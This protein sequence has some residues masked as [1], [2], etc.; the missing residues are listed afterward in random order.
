MKKAVSFIVLLAMLFTCSF[1]YAGSIA[2]WT[3]YTTADGSY[4]FHYPNS[5]KGWK[6]EANE[7]AVLIE[8]TQTDEQLLMAMIPYNKSKSPTSLAT[9]FINLLKAESPNVR[10][11]NWQTDPQAKNSQVFFDLTDKNNNKQYCGS[12]IV[13][14]DNQQATWFSYISPATG[15]SR[16]RGISLLQGFIG[17][18][19][20]GSG[21]IAPEINY[22]STYIARIDAN[23][24]GFLFV[25]EFA[26]GAPFTKSQEQVILDELKAGW[27][28]LTEEELAKY[29]QYP[30]LVKTILK[31][32]QKDLDK[33]RIE[34]EKSTREWIADSSDY[35]NAVKII[36]DQL[37]TRGR[38]VI[39]GS[40]PLTEMSLNAYSEIIA[41]SRL[42]RQNPK[43]LPDQ[44]SQDTVINV[45]KEVQSAWKSFTVNDRKDIA[46]SPGLWFC[47]RTLMKNGSK[48]EQEKIRIQLLKLTPE[49]QSTKTSAKPGTTS[50]PMSMAAHSSMLAIQQMT[51]N[52]YMWSRGFNYLPATGKMW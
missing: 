47:I 37:K 17:S 50:K 5:P 15:Y 7:S 4:S 20:S 24:Q 10:A 12:G 28:L 45:R 52:T 8:N 1:S 23:A 29:D 18:F 49:S 41:Y 31:M 30:V 6:A 25:L 34:L 2:L 9:D 13:I 27:R 48:T 46:T 16:D 51:F 11:S 26:L 38:N 21:S 3:K 42:L 35:D 22:S 39:A 33:L 32:G 19:A 43:A 44:I 40:P 36:Q 14:K